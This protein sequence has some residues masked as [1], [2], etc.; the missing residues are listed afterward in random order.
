VN[1]Q[2]AP[3]PR[4]VQH[5]VQI[6]AAAALLCAFWLALPVR[7]QWASS[8][9]S[10]EECLSL[11]DSPPSGT[12]DGLSALERCSALVADD[13]ELMADLGSQYESAGRPVDAEAVYRRALAIDPA[14]ADLHRRLA[15]LLLQ[16]GAA[17]EARVHAEEALRV[18]P[19]RRALQDILD[20]TSR[21]TRE[22]EP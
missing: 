10:T 4:S 12:P 17:L 7:I 9:P 1:R 11:A 18:Q 3:V 19:H 13:V 21:L 20:K 22:R 8:G 15:T 16:R 5:R 14:Y 2:Q 6:L